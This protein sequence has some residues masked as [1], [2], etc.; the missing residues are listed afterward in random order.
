MKQIITIAAIVLL[1]SCGLTRTPHTGTTTH[2]VT[3]VQNYQGG[4]AYR[5]TGLRGWHTGLSDTLKKGSV[6]TFQ[7][8]KN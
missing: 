2:T 8:N 3:A 7:W 5:L 1:S 6:V 4:K